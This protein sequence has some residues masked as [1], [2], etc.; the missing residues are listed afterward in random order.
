MNPE[1]N[2]LEFPDGDFS[3]LVPLLEKK[4]ADRVLR[5]AETYLVGIIGR[6]RLNSSWCEI[7]EEGSWQTEF[8][9]KLPE[10]QPE[11]KRAIE[12]ALEQSLKE[13]ERVDV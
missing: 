10:P 7:K 4:K 1:I 5:F 8:L 11:L 12:F 9:F 13:E 6:E 2:I 3:V